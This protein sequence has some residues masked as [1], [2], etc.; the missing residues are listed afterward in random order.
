M[1]LQSSL[2]TTILANL[3]LNAEPSPQYPCIRVSPCGSAAPA[4]RLQ[5]WHSVTPG[6]LQQQ[7]TAGCCLLSCSGCEQ[8]SLCLMRPALGREDGGHVQC[9][10]GKHGSGLCCLGSTQL[11]CGEF[12]VGRDLPF[13]NSPTKLITKHRPM[14]NASLGLISLSTTHSLERSTEQLATFLKTLPHAFSPH[15]PGIER[16]AGACHPLT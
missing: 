10:G 8:C 6:G 1:S 15:H 16:V 7:W 12:P 14:G 5:A 11:S 9:E 2:Q 13:P 4:C 3:Q